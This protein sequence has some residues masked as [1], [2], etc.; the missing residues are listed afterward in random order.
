VSEA[1]AVSFLV[2]SAA[3]CAARACGFAAAAPQLGASGRHGLALGYRAGLFIVVWICLVAAGAGGGVEK[4]LASGQTLELK[5]PGGLGGKPG[6]PVKL[7][8]HASVAFASGLVVAVALRFTFVAIEMAAAQLE[9]LIGLE[10]HAE[11]QEVGTGPLAQLYSIAAWAVFFTLGGHRAVLAALLSAAQGEAMLMSSASTI[12]LNL[13][14]LLDSTCALG[15][16][17]A[18]PAL[19]AM[20][21][22]RVVVAVLGRLL[23]QFPGQSVAAPVMI[24]FG[25]LLLLASLPGLVPA[26]AQL[27]EQAI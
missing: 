20:L 23:P 26:F 15:L 17:L 6:S 14:A 3:L 10:T 24:A 16:Q 2:H 1:S 18:G 11:D 7:A 9:P 21:A 8:L 19:A 12:T 27:I 13:A 25:L 22:A 4:M 5:L